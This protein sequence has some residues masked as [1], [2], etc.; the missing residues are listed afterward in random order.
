MDSNISNVDSSIYSVKIKTLFQPL[1]SVQN[2]KYSGVEA[3]S[4]GDLNGKFLNAKELF[5]L[6]T[7]ETENLYLNRICIKSALLAFSQLPKQDTLSLFINFDSALIDSQDIVIGT[8]LKVVNDMGLSPSQIVIELIESRVKDFERLLEF[9]H[10]YRSKGFLIALDDI[11]TGYSNFER[12][13]H[14]QPNLIKI[15]IKLVNGISNDFYKQSVCKS[16]IELAHNIGCLALAEGV[17]NLNDALMI[18]DLGADMIQG[19][20]FSKPVTGYNAT[21]GSVSISKLTNAWTNFTNLKKIKTKQFIDHVKLEI[22]TIA[23]LLQDSNIN[24]WDSILFSRAKDYHY[25]QCL[26]VLDS[27]GIQITETAISSKTS[28]KPHLLF[29]PAKKG[30][31]HS[32]KSYF[33]SRQEKQKWFI[34]D[35]YIS[36]ATGAICQTI[37]LLFHKLNS[38]YLLCLDISLENQ[39]TSFIL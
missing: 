5:S 15:D 4:R 36:N 22:A 1:Y 38:C 34:S 32:F 39:D 9:I 26:Y 13:V 11:G 25:A 8:M 33:V 10:F 24:N 20:Y 3:L 19:F 2:K 7:N 12:I 14:I 35:S 28:Q 30:T 21:N 16:L 17:E 31:D 23:T 37:I 29:N 18:Q 27:S 6:P